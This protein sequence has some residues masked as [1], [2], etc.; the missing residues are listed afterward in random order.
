[1]KL[2]LLFLWLLAITYSCSA[3]AQEIDPVK[4]ANALNEQKSD[5]KIV[6]DAAAVFLVKSADARMMDMQEGKLA[7]KRGS[8]AAIRQYGQLMEK[9]QAFLLAKIRRLA[10]HKQ[11][12]LPTGISN[13]KQEGREDLMEKSGQD[14]DKKFIKMM[15]LDHER[16]VKLFKKAIK[17]DD[18]EISLFANKHLPMIQNHLDKINQLEEMNK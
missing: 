10:A 1:M 5:H 17:S 11:I 12:S 7:S 8:S 6:D 9:D 4:K 16:D 15:K 3:K 14:F 18:R 2:F 13:Q